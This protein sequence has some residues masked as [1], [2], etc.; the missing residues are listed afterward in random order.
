M[1][2]YKDYIK[3][4]DLDDG[5]PEGSGDITLSLLVSGFGTDGN[6]GN[7][8]LPSFS[9]EASG[10]NVSYGD[11]SLP[12]FQ[13]NGHANN[14]G[15]LTLP[16]LSLSATRG[17]YGIGDCQIAFKVVGDG[18]DAPT[19]GGDIDLPALELLA[20]G[21]PRMKIYELCNNENYGL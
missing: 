7:V 5:D 10:S 21:G 12:I 20:N 2:N 15:S 16:S 1:A 8:S 6:Y 14:Y 18:N 9:Q 3:S 11:V 4:L 13:I 17:Q 19:L